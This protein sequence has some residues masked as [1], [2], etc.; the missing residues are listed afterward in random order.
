M[1]SF[2]HLRVHS[3]Y[4]I[5]D[6]L[7]FPQALVKKAAELGYPSLALTDEANM[8]AVLKF[9][10]AAQEH[11]IKPILGMDLWLID[12]SDVRYRVTALV[13]NKEGYHNLMQLATYAQTTSAHN[14]Q[15]GCVSR[16]FFADHSQGLVVLSGGIQGD[17]GQDLSAGNKTAAGEKLRW[18]MDLCGDNYYLELQCLGN[19]DEETFT[20]LSLALAQEYKCPP[21]ATNLVCFL[22]AQDFEAHSLRVCIH[23]NEVLGREK[24]PY[25]YQATQYMRSPAEMAKLFADVRLP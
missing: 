9:F 15:R 1:S 6:G 17:I 16:E 23:H 13:K 20:T 24:K 12:Q 2:I 5:K 7:S 4:S 18:W 22:T 25:P 8:F 10:H 11:G 21:V 19:A 14:Y 3:A